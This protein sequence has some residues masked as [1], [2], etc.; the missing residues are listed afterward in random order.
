[1]EPLRRTAADLAR[2]VRVRA[3]TTSPSRSPPPSPSSPSMVQ[4]Q[5]QEQEQ[6]REKGQGAPARLV[7]ASDV[8]K[9]RFDRTIARRFG[10]EGFD[11]VRYLRLQSRAGRE[12][13]EGGDGKEERKAF[14]AA[15]HRVEDE[16]ELE[17]GERWG[18][19]G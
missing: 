11:V 9:D 12:G 15:V 3:S 14:E 8:P 16:L 7:I 17:E 18:V 4:E 5:D 2:R 1:M 6:G 19:V 10:D 13:G